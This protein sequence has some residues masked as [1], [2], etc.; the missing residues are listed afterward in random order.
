MTTSTILS[1]KQSPGNL[2]GYF[3]TAG[4]TEKESQKLEK[5]PYDFGSDGPLRQVNRAESTPFDTHGANRPSRDG[6]PPDPK[7]P[8]AF[9]GNHF[10]V[11]GRYHSSYAFELS[12]T[13]HKVSQ[14]E[15]R[16]S[17]PRDLCHPFVLIRQQSP[18]SILPHDRVP[19]GSPLIC[20]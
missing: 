19:A 18:R 6:L 7:G 2:A 1:V 9:F 14:T 16:I 12:L 3:Q 4:H 13:I 17:P 15:V 11:T 10:G 20:T 5:G 8:N